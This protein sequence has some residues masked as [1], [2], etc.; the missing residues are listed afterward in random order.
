MSQ[1]DQIEILVIEPKCSFKHIPDAVLVF[2]ETKLGIVCVLYRYP[3]VFLA[4]LIT[5]VV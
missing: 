5:D 4:P 1:V 2:N 3:S